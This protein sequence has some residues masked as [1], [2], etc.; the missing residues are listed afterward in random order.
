MVSNGEGSNG[1]SLTFKIKFHDSSKTAYKKAI[2]GQLHSNSY[3]LLI[4]QTFKGLHHEVQAKNTRGTRNS[5][6]R[7]SDLQS[8]TLTTALL[9]TE[10]RRPER[11]G[12][13]L[14]CREIF[15][16]Y[17]LEDGVGFVKN[18]RKKMHRSSSV[19]KSPEFLQMKA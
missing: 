6:S 10:N 7:P 11:R 14:G 17:A 3:Q 15:T 2:S 4:K 1:A 13:G 8:D 18:C 12:A 9:R 19:T 5:N 16:L